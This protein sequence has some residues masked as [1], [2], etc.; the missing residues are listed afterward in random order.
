MNLV[1][2]RINTTQATAVI[3]S[4]IKNNAKWWSEGQLGDN[5]FVQGL[6]YMITN[7][8]IKINT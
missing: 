3:P 6:Q 4:W 2:V 5:Q 1:N 7:G 8:I